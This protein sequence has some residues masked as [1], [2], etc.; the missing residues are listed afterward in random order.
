MLTLWIIWLVIAF[1]ALGIF[2][3]ARALWNDRANRRAR[4][5]VQQLAHDNAAAVRAL[6]AR[7]GQRAP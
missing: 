5:R 3:L 2:A 7:T 6:Y 1:S 4:R